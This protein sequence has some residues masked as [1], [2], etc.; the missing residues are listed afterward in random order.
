MIFIKFL[1]FRASFLHKVL[2]ALSGIIHGRCLGECL[3]SCEHL[4]NGG[5]CCLLR[6]IFFMFLSLLLSVIATVGDVA[7]K[8]WV[9]LLPY[10][11]PFLH[12]AKR[13]PV[14]EFIFFLICLSQVITTCLR[15]DKDGSI[16]R[17]L[18]CPT[19]NKLTA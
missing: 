5:Q 18:L 11:C 7:A 17:P 4:I 6:L 10:V 19:F 16:E 3:A 1:N 2:Y 9:L 14:T 15:D 8:K 13:S 12:E